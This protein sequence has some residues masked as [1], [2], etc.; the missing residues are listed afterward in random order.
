M[1]WAKH[2]SYETYGSRTRARCASR[3]LPFPFAEEDAVAL[4][5]YTT[6]G[7]QL[8][9]EVSAEHFLR[10]YVG[11]RCGTALLFFGRRWMARDAFG[12]I[13]EVRPFQRKTRETC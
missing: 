6:V 2:R 10:L 11:G 13:Y 12:R 4:F 9:S 7:E 1:L 3:E 5:I 8:R